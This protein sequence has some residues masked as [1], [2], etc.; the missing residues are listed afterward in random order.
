MELKIRIGNQEFKNP[1]FVAS[2]TFGYGEE[3]SKIFDISKLG[4]IITKGTTLNPRAGY[5]GLRIVETPA[6]IINRIGL[7]NVG[8]EKFMEYKIPFLET[9][10]TGVIVNVAGESISE[11]VQII[12]KL[13]QFDSIDGFE[14]NVSCPNIEK[15]GIEF[16]GD[17]DVYKKLLEEIKRVSKKMLIIKLS[18]SV[19]NIVRFSQI[20]EDKG[21]DAITINNTFK[22][23]VIDI[24]TRSVKITGGLSG[25]AIYPIS[26]HNLMEVYKE[27]NIPVIGSG[28]IYKS[29]IALQFILGG[30]SA[31]QIGSFNFVKPDIGLQ[32]VEG[33]KEYLM[34]NKIESIYDIIG[35]ANE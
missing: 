24:N 25:P 35:V 14:I 4:A 6:G 2:G 33:I 16:S 7:Q 22:G 26:L 23:S 18:P 34:E 30:A 1:V 3:Y 10:G 12:E 17:E 5:D 20:A 19:G 11:Y 13:N 28:G 31:V 15:G 27:V 9:V 29:D 21:F 8:L 32:I